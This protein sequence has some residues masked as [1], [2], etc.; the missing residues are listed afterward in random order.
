VDIRRGGLGRGA[1]LG[2]ILT[3][4]AIEIGTCFPIIDEVAQWILNLGNSPSEKE[5]C[6][7]NS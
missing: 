2:G 3:S 5:A 4:V 1:K 7:K 6:W